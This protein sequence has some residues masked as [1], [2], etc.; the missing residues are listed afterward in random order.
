M[1]AK[2]WVVVG[3]WGEGAAVAEVAEVGLVVVVWHSLRRAMEYSPLDS[4]SAQIILSPH[5]PA[6]I[7]RGEI[8]N[9][10]SDFGRFCNYM[11]IR[12]WS[13]SGGS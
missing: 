3:D 9:P 11:H 2:V 13:N 10:D 6:R 12:I 1:P 8:A 7:C 5:V 4:L